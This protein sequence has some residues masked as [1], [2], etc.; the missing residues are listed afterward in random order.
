MVSEGARSAVG[1]PC[2]QP[3]TGSPTDP[4]SFSGQARGSKTPAALLSASPTWRGGK[5]PDRHP[6]PFPF[7]FPLSL[8]PFPPFPPFPPSLLFPFLLSPLSPSF[9]LS[10]SLSS[11]PFPFPSL[12]PGQCGGSRLW[13][14][15]AEAFPSRCCKGRSLH[16]VPS[17][18]FLSALLEGAA[19]ARSRPARPGRLRTAPAAL[20]PRGDTAG[21]AASSGRCVSRSYSCTWAVWLRAG[22]APKT[23]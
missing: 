16:P 22:T 8:P 20:L 19:G 2:S 3:T 7:P 10:F 18:L 1:E 17:L 6:F 5:Q 13:T 23:S 11:F 15:A 4:T 12:T 21:A 9:S 14:L